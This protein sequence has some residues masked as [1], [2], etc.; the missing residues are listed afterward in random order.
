MSHFLLIYDRLEGQLLSMDRFGSSAEA[1]QARFRA[2]DRF[3]DQ[4][5]VEVVALSA[6]SEVDLKRTH[7]RF[8][9]GLKELAE[10]STLGSARKAA[11]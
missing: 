3:S 6:E 5:D 9:L 11:T 8:F 4:P 10:M 1:M 2:E 7:G